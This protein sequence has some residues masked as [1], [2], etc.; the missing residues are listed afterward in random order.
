[1]LII[2]DNNVCKVCGAY[3][4]NHNICANGHNNIPEIKEK[5]KM[6]KKEIYKIINELKNKNTSDKLIQNRMCNYIEANIDEFIETYE[7]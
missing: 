2:D 4:D 1:M 6:E 3:M 5:I 7:N